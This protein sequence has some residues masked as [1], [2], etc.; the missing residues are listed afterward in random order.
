[1]RAFSTKV[2]LLRHGELEQQNVLAGRTDFLLSD[3]GYLQLQNKVK[4]LTHINTVI[5][6][7]LNRCKIFADEYASLQKIPLVIDEAIAEYNFGDWDG[8]TFDMLW[9]QSDSPTI[10]DF[11]QDPW[12][13]TPPDGES[14]HQFYSRVFTWW[15]QLIKTISKQKLGSCLVVTH[16]GV[17][18]QLLAIICQFPQQS[19]TAHNVFSIP[20]AGLICIEIYI[21]EQGGAWPKIVF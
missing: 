10:G 13:I 7:P 1:M 4:F 20:Y 17:I 19:T 9:R 8:L 2:Y 11:W 18:K 5:S 14:M 15:Q 3:R 12:Q 16:G 21:D 6:S